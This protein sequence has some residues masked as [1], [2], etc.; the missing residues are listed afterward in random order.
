MELNSDRPVNMKIILI[1]FMG[2]GKS[3]FAKRLA[4]RLG[5]ENIKMD[6]L[7]LKKSGRKTVKEIFEKDGEMK[8][9]EFEIEVAR[10]LQGKDDVVIDTGG[11][12]VQNKIILDYLR[13]DGIVVF[14][15]SSLEIIKKRLG[16]DKTRPLLKD[17][18]KFRQLYESRMPL[19]QRYA[20]VVVD[21]SRLISFSV[22]G[23]SD[24]LKPETEELLENI[25]KLIKVHIKEEGGTC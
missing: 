5:L 7:V 22:D 19:Y 24:K 1:G 23:K 25:I 11:G 20:D 12:V 2:A 13:K 3:F 21:T 14:L 18:E 16:G 10:E 17:K 4:N 6:E 15:D 8:F 9:R